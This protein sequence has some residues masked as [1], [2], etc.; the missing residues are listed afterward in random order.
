M[1]ISRKSPRLLSAITL[2]AFIFALAMPCITAFAATGDKVFDIIEITDFHGTLEDNKG[3]PVAAVMAKNIKNIVNG[4]PGRTLIVSGGDNYQGAVLSNL[5]KG[6][7]VMSAFN[8]IGVAV[9][10][11][12]NH[13]FDWGLGTV[14]KPGIANTQLFVPTCFTRAPISACLTLTKFLKKM[15]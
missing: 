7:P 4:N 8:S 11:L 5:L 1:F 6:A 13:E 14:T 15:V 3:N 9:S 2:L 12:G 10:E